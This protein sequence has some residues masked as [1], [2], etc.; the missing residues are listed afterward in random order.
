MMS[1]RLSNKRIPAGRRVFGIVVT[2]AIGF[3]SVLGLSGGPVAADT[4]Y[5]VRENDTLS[6]VAVRTGIPVQ[7]IVAANSL[8]DPNHVRV[9]Q[10]L[11]IPDTVGDRGALVEYAV[12]AGDTLSEIALH[13]GISTRELAEINNLTDRHTIRVGRALL[14][15]SGTGFAVGSSGSYSQLPERIVNNPDRLALVGYFEKW[16]AANEIPVD[17]LM[18]IAWQESGWNN[19]ALS[20][21]GARGIGQIMPETGT[22][23]A[24]SL[25]G[26]PELDPGLP[27]DNI[28][29]SARYVGWLLERMG[30]ERLAIAA[31]YQGPGSVSSGPLFSSTELYIENVQVHRQFFVSN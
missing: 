11:V 17:L 15:P 31:Y 18:A 9:G 1:P 24:A 8:S 5:V 13:A 21:K 23:V 29:I 30:D 10:S 27:E 28:R 14:V 26:H 6:H 19:A 25:I 22:W 2:G 16:A 4:T 12:V 3:T 7:A 20:Y